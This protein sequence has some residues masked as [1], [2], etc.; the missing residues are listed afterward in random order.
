MTD[1]IFQQLFDE[2]KNP[3]V[4]DYEIDGVIYAAYSQSVPTDAVGDEID[5]YIFLAVDK[6]SLQDDQIA[7]QTNLDN[8]LILCHIMIQIILTAVLG[9]VL[10]I[11]WWMGQRIVRPIGYDILAP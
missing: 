3:T 9:V 11:A 7:L 6:S 5:Y 1:Q 8:E 10:F 4:F 2:I